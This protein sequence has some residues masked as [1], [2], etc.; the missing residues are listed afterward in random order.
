MRLGFAERA[1][2]QITEAASEEKAKFLVANVDGID[3]RE[4][5]VEKDQE[6]QRRAAAWE[7]DSASQALLA[8]WRDQNA[9]V[10]P[11]RQ[12]LSGIVLGNGTFDGL[13]FAGAV[14]NY[15][16]LYHASFKNTRFQKAQLKFVFIGDEVD[17][18]GADFS[19]LEGEDYKGSR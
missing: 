18:A 6:Q 12:N 8:L 11:S 2:N 19:G 7:I 3:S 13:D 14:L 10:S 16:I 15:G 4:D 5:V 9:H 17:L 1:K